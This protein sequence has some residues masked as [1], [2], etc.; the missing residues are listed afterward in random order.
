MFA[1]LRLL[2]AAFLLALGLLL[3]TTVLAASGAP[4]QRVPFLVAGACYAL[5]LLAAHAALRW[6]AAPD[7]VTVRRRVVFPLGFAAA[8]EAFMLSALP[9]P[10]RRAELAAFA[11]LA[12]VLLLTAVSLV[13]AIGE[14]PGVRWSLLA[15]ALW[16]A[17]VIGRFFWQ[18]PAPGPHSCSAPSWRS[19]RISR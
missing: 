2:A 5:G 14:R 18:F 13:L 9:W 10:P 7:R 12:A 4:P 19:A 17:F 11:P 16:A 1:L 15:L 3:G 6:R 8:A